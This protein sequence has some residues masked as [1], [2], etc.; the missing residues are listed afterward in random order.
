[1]TDL[2]FKLAV[3]FMQTTPIAN[4]ETSITLFIKKINFKMKKIIL[5]MT[6]MLFALT[7]NA[8]I[9]VVNNG[10]VGIGTNYVPSS[11]K[12]L[13]DA[14]KNRALLLKTNH[15]SDWWQSSAA[16]VSRPNTISWAV[17]Y[18][19]KDR[20]YVSGWGWLYAN[21][22]WFGSDKR[23]KKDIVTLQ[24][25]L[26]KVMAL[27]G[28]SYL[29][30]SEANAHKMSL[31][32]S[33]TYDEKEKPA[34]KIGFIA[35][36]VEKIVPEL[37]KIMPDGTKALAY[38]NVT[39]LNVEAIKEQQEKI[40]SINEEI[41]DLR[42]QLKK[43]SKNQ[44]MKAENTGKTTLYQNKPNPFTETT[45]I[46]YEINKANFISA[47]IRIFDLNGN[48]VKAYEIERAGKNKLSINGGV[49]TA[50]MYIYTLIVN[51]QEI[52]SK[53]MILLNK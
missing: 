25:P 35:D 39:A 43:V 23:L 14:G 17:R 13:I 18:G 40:E 51:N 46:E 32:K 26:E 21:G 6:I 7:V 50:G 33:N 5:S 44:S 22:A 47:S 30:K 41:S 1:M 53:R 52:D 19:G 24:S 34:R 9:K 29:L 27:R 42:E 8:Q 38:H 10:R 4:K 20:F 37:V 2:K 45:I 36:E 11:E 12:M 49:L 28:V 48:H 15:N 3:N 31:D 16:H